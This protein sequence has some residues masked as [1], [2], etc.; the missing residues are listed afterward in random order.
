M[1]IRRRPMI[2]AQSNPINISPGRWT[3]VRSRGMAWWRHQMETFSALLALCA[4]NSPIT[5]E[6]PAQWPVTRSFDAFFDQRI[7]GWV[8][9]GEAG[10]LRRHRTHYD[11]TVM[12]IRQDRKGGFMDMYIRFWERH[13]KEHDVIVH[14]PDSLTFDWITCQRGR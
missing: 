11:V 6:F 10:D 4:G 2:K 7:D 1:S 8:N 14:D 13:L 12:D 5:G 3:Y 9:N